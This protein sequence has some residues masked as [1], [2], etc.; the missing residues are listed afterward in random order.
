MQHFYYVHIK[1]WTS[2]RCVGYEHSDYY[3][4][5]FNNFIDDEDNE[6][7]MGTYPIN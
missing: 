3:V 7:E 6:S 1:I 4:G 5:N 2:L